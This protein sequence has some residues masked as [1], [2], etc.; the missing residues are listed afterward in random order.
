MLL[1]RVSG[2]EPQANFAVP[3]SIRGERELPNDLSEDNETDL[4]KLGKSQ[5][6]VIKETA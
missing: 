1:F 6:W 2:P 5:I 3:L 4:V